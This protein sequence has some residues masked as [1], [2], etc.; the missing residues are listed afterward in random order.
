M[1][2]LAEISFNICTTTLANTRRKS[3][4]YIAICK[5]CC[6]VLTAP[7]DMS[8]FAGPLGGSAAGVSEQ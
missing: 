3:V 1:L 4:Y 7:V 5:N 8:F 6:E 2:I